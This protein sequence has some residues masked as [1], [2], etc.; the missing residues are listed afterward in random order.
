MWIKVLQNLEVLLLAILF[1]VL[2]TSMNT[3]EERAKKEEALK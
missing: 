2:F 1:S 3:R